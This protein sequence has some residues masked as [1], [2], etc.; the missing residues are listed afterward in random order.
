MTLVPVSLLQRSCAA[1]MHLERA[2]APE[3]LLAHKRGSSGSPPQACLLR[4]WT[5]GAV[6]T[7]AGG[8]RAGERPRDLSQAFCSSCSMSWCSLR[9]WCTSPRTCS[10]HA[11]S[12]NRRSSSEKAPQYEDHVGQVGCPCAYAGCTRPPDGTSHTR[13]FGT[14]GP[15]VTAPD[16]AAAW[17]EIRDTV[18][19]AVEHSTARSCWAA[20][21]A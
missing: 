12:A 5:Q 11:A 9:S 16:I 21:H 14:P 6:C 18:P 1:G 13:F 17:T 7:P 4:A 10:Q 15:P 19:G 20:R 2:A 8:S 3:P